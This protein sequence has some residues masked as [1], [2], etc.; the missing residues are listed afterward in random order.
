MRYPGTGSKVPQKSADDLRPKGSSP[1]IAAFLVVAFRFW[2]GSHRPQASL[3]TNRR[4]GM[5]S[6]G[7]QGPRDLNGLGRPSPKKCV[8]DKRVTDFGAA[9]DSSVEVGTSGFQ[10]ARIGCTGS[11][12]SFSLIGVNRV[13]FEAKRRL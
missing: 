7:D 13:F 9:E 1:F 12:R 2:E 3:H 10:S 8:I 6:D 5:F 11:K 4:R